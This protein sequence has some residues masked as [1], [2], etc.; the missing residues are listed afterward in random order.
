MVHHHR[1]F[2]LIEFLI[3][4][5][6]IAILIA[7]ILPSLK[8]ARSA[9][10]SVGCLSNEKQFAIALHLFFEDHNGLFPYANNYA[11]KDTYWINNLAPYYNAATE[12]DEKDSEWHDPARDVIYLFNNPTA[13]SAH[14]IVMGSQFMF[15][16]SRVNYHRTSIDDVKVPTKTMWMHCG[17]TYTYMPGVWAPRLTG[18]HNG[19]EN[20]VFIDGHAATFKSQ[21]FWDWHRKSGSWAYTNLPNRHPGR[22]EWWTVPW[23]PDLYPYRYSTGPL[24]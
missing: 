6:I 3:V 1:A 9:A 20:F 4:I 16:D 13:R 23:Y 15:I 11:K 12:V 2:T 14:Y 10:Q 17:W 19:G 18:A 24:P 7:I 5:T 8:A 21:P 22:A